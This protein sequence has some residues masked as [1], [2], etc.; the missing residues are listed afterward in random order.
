MRTWVLVDDQSRIEHDLCRLVTEKGDRL[1]YVLPCV[2]SKRFN[3]D[4]VAAKKR[5]VAFEIEQVCGRTQE[6]TATALGN[7]LGSFRG[8][9][10][11]ILDLLL[12]ALAETWTAH[13]PWLSK[14]VEPQGNWLV[15]PIT[16]TNKL[17]NEYTSAVRGFP[18]R[19]SQFVQGA[20]NLSG[21]FVAVPGY[22]PDGSGPA[23]DPRSL[24]EIIEQAWTKNFGFAHGRYHLNDAIDDA[25]CFYARPWAQGVASPPKWFTG[26]AHRDPDREQRRVLFDWISTGDSGIGKD[27]SQWGFE[28]SEA[29]ERFWGLDL[30][31]S[32]AKGLLIWPSPDTQFGTYWSANGDRSSREG[33]PIDQRVLAAV[34]RRLGCTI[35]GS[36]PGMPFV[37]PVEPGFFWL[38]SLVALHDA[39]YADRNK[40]RQGWPS[41]D[42]HHEKPILALDASVTGAGRRQYRVGVKTHIASWGM[43]DAWHARQHRKDLLTYVSMVMAASI[44]W[45][46]E[47]ELKPVKEWLEALKG[48]VCGVTFRPGWVDFLWFI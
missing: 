23:A 36:I 26:D 33:Y 22:N 38:L 30:A 18:E 15:C 14:Y 17:D 39:L 45:Q 20:Q 9:R 32:T 27:P 41:P 44:E 7:K 3:D 21:R 47:G 8:D 29:L 48:P 35:E 28:S 10:I 12:Q 1:V 5:D 40:A 11:L 43:R 46:H 2:G 34:L 24:V 37:L 42:S 25:L 16:G 13:T 19:L 4:E 31:V 6:E